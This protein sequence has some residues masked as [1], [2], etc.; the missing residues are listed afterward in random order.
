M[1]QTESMIGPRNPVRL[2][3][4]TL[5]ELGV[6]AYDGWLATIKG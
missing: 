6:A 3:I 5:K 2:A 1:F 4:D